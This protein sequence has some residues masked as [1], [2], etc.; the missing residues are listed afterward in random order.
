MSQEKRNVFLISAN[1]T[2]KKIF[3]ESF[4]HQPKIDL[5]GTSE[6]SFLPIEELTYSEPD[7]VVIDSVLYEE[8]K[9]LVRN[10]LEDFPK[11]TIF[12][13]CDL[14][15]PKEVQ[16]TTRAL[17]LGVADFI[18]KPLDF[19]EAEIEK[20]RS[21]LREKFLNWKIKKETR[22]TL[23][24]HSSNIEFVNRYDIIG[25]VS[26][27]GS[28]SAIS[29][30]LPQLPKDFPLPILIQIDLPNVF[31]KPFLERL[32]QISHLYVKEVK[33][34]D[35]LRASTVYL[36]FGRALKFFPSPDKKHVSIQL[37]ESQS[38]NGF[39]QSMI[40]IFPSRSIG[41]FLT[42]E[43]IHLAEEIRLFKENKGFVILQ[44]ETTSITWGNAK[45]LYDL[46]LYDMVLPIHEIADKLCQLAWI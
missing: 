16:L 32:N 42:G 35:I 23:P 4:L 44:D 8:E 1:F 41:V 31:S 13:L 2:I 25:I 20:F 24:V 46:G 27:R 33:G 30:L 10:L 5:C 7:F 43:D 38:M 28:F 18:Q 40:Q 34:T 22:L 19:S 26:G 11:I 29:K 21:S 17:C 12:M 14:Y 39:F 36:F 37:G 6:S 15:D 3:I 9:G 45:E